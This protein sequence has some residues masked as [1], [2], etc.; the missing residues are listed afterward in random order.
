VSLTP[1]LPE[2]FALLEELER[3]R[4]PVLSGL[5]RGAEPLLLARAPGRLDVMG[6]FA[7]YSGSLTLELPIAEA[8][9]V[10]LQP[11]AEPTLEL[12]SAGSAAS[13]GALRSA[14]FPLDELVRNTQSYAEARAYFQRDASSRWAAY[15]AGCCAAL[16]LELGLEQRRGASLLVF[17]S[18]P[19]GKGVS[20]SAALEVATLGVLA[21]QHGVRIAPVRS[22]LICQRVEN[23]VVGAP[24]GVMDQMTS[25][26]GRE[27]Q[28][29]ALLCQPAQ[30]EPSLAVPPGL[31]LWG[32]DSG[33]RHEV[34]GA[35]YTEVRVAAFMG[36]RWIAE[37]RGLHV[38]A[39]D[40]DGHVHIE[41]PQWGGYLARLAPAEFDGRYRERLPERIGGAEFL[42]RLGGISD[43]ITDVRPGASYRVRA[44]TAHPVYEHERAGEFRSLLQSPELA[45]AGAL[46]AQ[47]RQRVL[48]E[49]L[50]ALMYEPHASYSAC[51][52]GSSGTDR[53]VELVRE[54]GPERG[55]FGAKIT[56]GG[57]GGTVAVLGQASA[58]RAVREVVDRYAGETGRAPHLFSGSSPGAA[59]FGVRRLERGPLG[60]RVL[61][62]ETERG[63]A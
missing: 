28:L 17:S 6:G 59:A 11:H 44:A 29:L 5:F 26:C 30:L 56:G 31:A 52:L 23:L 62:R 60:F 35:D 37:E 16:R 61:A 46:P 22:A 47:G 40:R 55:L 50:G 9:F 39:S 45:A 43:P 48:L 13:G 49:R 34:S 38:S 53:I 2:L 12:V 24:C 63:N 20:S 3:S 1:G 51:G 57:S 58:A 41:D 54:L 15:V 4:D 25:S 18:V 8:A 27:G 21:G 32:I 14:V 36:Y 19:E 42:Q 10:V 7:D 33:L